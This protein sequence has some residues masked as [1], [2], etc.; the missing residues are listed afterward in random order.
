[1]LGRHSLKFGLDIRYNRLSNRASFDSKGTWV[2]SSLQEF[3]NN[4]A[5]VSDSGGE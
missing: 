5:S 3:M 4:Q 1:M 2:F